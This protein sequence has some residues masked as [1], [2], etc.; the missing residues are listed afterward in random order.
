MHN[1]LSTADNVGD[2]VNRHLAANKSL[3]IIRRGITLSVTLVGVA[4]SVAAI[5][6]PDLSTPQKAVIIGGIVLVSASFA[7]G[8]ETGC[9][10]HAPGANGIVAR[11]YPRSQHHE[12]FSD[13]EQLVRVASNITLIATGMN[14]LWEK[15]SLI[16]L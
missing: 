2:A 12:F 10:Q 16:C 5:L 4:A 8:Y 7:I 1:L 3:A 14:M 9:R 6:V 11:T 15:I 13:V